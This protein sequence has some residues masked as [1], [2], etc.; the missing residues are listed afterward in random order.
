M[1][2]LT[3]SDLGTVLIWYDSV[4]KKESERLDLQHCIWLMQLEDELALCPAHRYAKRVLDIGTG[5]GVWAIDFADSFPAAH[6]IGA[7]LSPIQPEWTPP[8]CVFEVD[9]LEKPWTWSQ[10]FD[11][12]YCRSMDGAFSDRKEMLRQ[13]YE[14]AFF[15]RALTPGGFFE[16]A[17][18]ELPLGCDDGTVPL[19]SNLWRWHSLLQEAAIKIGR[20]LESLAH[21]QGDLEEAGFVNVVRKDSKLPLNSWPTEPHLKDLGRWQYVNLTSGLE[22]LSLG[23]LTRVMGWSR[24]EVLDLCSRVQQDLKDKRMHAYWKIHIVYAQK[25]DNAME[26]SWD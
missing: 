10:P 8:N 4:L 3:Y 19:D 20:P 24:D 9:D 12:I 18:L 6:V 26:T 23:L 17:G 13:V 25:P 1:R 7:D 16:V 22:G 15:H 5:T 2:E 11:F 14:S 21:N